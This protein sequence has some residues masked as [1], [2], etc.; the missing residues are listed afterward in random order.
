MWIH[1][2][3]KARK[4]ETHGALSSI[5]LNDARDERVI[6]VLKH[7]QSSRLPSRAGEEKGNMRRLRRE[8]RARIIDVLLG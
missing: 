4:R 6:S 8:E 1:D 2:T 5:S 3:G 7:S